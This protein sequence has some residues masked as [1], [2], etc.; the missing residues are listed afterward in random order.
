MHVEE[1]GILLLG[2]RNWDGFGCTKR[3]EIGCSVTGVKKLH[4][5]KILGVLLIGVENQNYGLLIWC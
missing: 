1:L 2:L 3:R 4:E 5:E